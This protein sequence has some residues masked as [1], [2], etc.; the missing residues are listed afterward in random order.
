MIHVGK[1]QGGEQLVVRL[2]V[3]A[4]IFFRLGVLLQDR[5]DNRGDRQQ[6]Q[7]DDCQLEGTEKIPDPVDGVSLCA[8]QNN[9]PESNACHPGEKM[10]DSVIISGDP[11]QVNTRSPH[12]NSVEPSF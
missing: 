5:P 4:N 7:G 8:C 6:Q 12:L 1:L 10:T 2:S 9:S 3:L 11:A